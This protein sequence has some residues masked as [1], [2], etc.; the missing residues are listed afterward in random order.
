MSNER[1]NKKLLC[2]RVRFVKDFDGVNQ[3]S[4]KTISA[5]GA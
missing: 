1:S 3:S 2:F 5:N 4:E